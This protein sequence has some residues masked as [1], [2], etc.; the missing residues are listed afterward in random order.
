[1]TS[2]RHPTMSE[3][4]SVL[5][6]IRFLPIGQDISELAARTIASWY[7]DGSSWEVQ[8]FVYSGEIVTKDLFWIITKQGRV[9]DEATAEEKLCLDH[10][11]EYLVNRGAEPIDEWRELWERSLITA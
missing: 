5:K 11:G 2:E 1:M 3:F 4:E 9:Y 10:L 6:E 8:Q 7:N